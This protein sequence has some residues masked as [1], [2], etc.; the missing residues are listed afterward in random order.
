RWEQAE[1]DHG[2]RPQVAVRLAEVRDQ[3]FRARVAAATAR[4]WAAEHRRDW[5][6]A[7]AAYTEAL[8]LDASHQPALEGLARTGEVV[9]AIIRFDRL[10]AEASALALRGDFASAVRSFNLAMASKPDYLPLTE[11][12]AALK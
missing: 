11:Q 3:A 10:L 6:A 2:E 7:R 12:A 8:D 4:G 1:R 5:T 9:R